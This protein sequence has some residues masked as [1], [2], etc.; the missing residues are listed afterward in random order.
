MGNQRHGQHY[1]GPAGI[2]DSAGT[3]DPTHVGR[4]DFV[5]LHARRSQPYSVADLRFG[6][7][8]LYGHL[9]RHWRAMGS[10]G[11]R[12][13]SI[14]F[15]NDDGHRAGM[16]GGGEDRRYDGLTASASDGGAHN[17]ADGRA[18]F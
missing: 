2:G 7:G 6:A 5:S 13:F 17:P 3:R 15:E 11:H 18:D 1:R 10:P 12:S 9:Y 16:G 14:H 8:A 4:P